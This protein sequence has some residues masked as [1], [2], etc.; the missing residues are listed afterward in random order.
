MVRELRAH[1]KFVA[2][3]YPPDAEALSPLPP[4]VTELTGFLMSAATERALAG[5]DLA[6]LSIPAAADRRILLIGRDRVGV[7]ESLRTHLAS[8]GADVTV[9]STSD[10][11]SLMTEPQEAEVPLATIDA[12]LSWL[13]QAPPASPAGVATPAAGPYSAQRWS[14]ARAAFGFARPRW[15]WRSPAGGCSASSASR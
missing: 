13:G 5:L 10:H 9:T 4:D 12:T 15:F 11:A 14:S 8:S 1:S 7:D 2:A 6:E 3:R